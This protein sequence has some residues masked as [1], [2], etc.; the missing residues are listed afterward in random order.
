MLTAISEKDEN[1]VKLQQS[2]AT[3]SKRISGRGHGRFVR[4]SSLP[5]A[6]FFSFRY[7]WTA[8]TRSSPRPGLPRRSHWSPGSLGHA[9]RL[10]PRVQ[11]WANQTTS[12][13]PAQ[14]YLH[15]NSAHRLRGGSVRCWQ[16]VRREGT[17]GRGASCCWLRPPERRYCTRYR[18][19]YLRAR[20]CRSRSRACSPASAACQ[21]TRVQVQIGGH[22]LRWET[23]DDNSTVSVG[24]AGK[25]ALAVKWRD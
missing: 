18:R 13:S 7:P 2:F 4:D 24:C 15:K 1:D 16:H 11:T 19:P 21:E 22:F 9:H 14:T 20:G 25:Q 17:R 5:S 3:D 12:R 6:Y 23:S 10:L 8:G